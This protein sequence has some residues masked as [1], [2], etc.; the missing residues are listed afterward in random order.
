MSLWQNVAENLEQKTVF[1]NAFLIIENVHA[2]RLSFKLQENKYEK[3]TWSS[4]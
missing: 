3:I 4:I 1:K 2:E